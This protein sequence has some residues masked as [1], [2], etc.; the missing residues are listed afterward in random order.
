MGR[1]TPYL[2]FAP[3]NKRLAWGLLVPMLLVTGISGAG[4][5]DM[6]LPNLWK[7]ILPAI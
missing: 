2:V 5:K 1:W 3:V 6:A 4:A 7:D